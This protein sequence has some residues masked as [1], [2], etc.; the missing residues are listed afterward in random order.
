MLSH[1]FRFH[2]HKSLGFVFRH[3]AVA[4]GRRLTV[5]LHQH[6]KRTRSRVAVVVSKK[7][8]KQATV[9]NRIRRRVYEVMRVQGDQ[10]PAPYDM[11]LI[12]M[13]R[14]VEAMP[15]EELQQEIIQLIRQGK[16]LHKQ[17]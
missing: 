1:R 15:F 14:E 8:A 12:V 3:G 13:S 10:L 5:R 17:G 11:V 16:H 4:R 6:P 2:G 7:I 9:R